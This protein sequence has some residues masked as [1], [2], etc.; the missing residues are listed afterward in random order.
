[1]CR[2]EPM[3]ALAPDDDRYNP[4]LPFSLSNRRA[5]R[6]IKYADGHP[7]EEH[8]HRKN[9]AGEDKILRR[10]ISIGFVHMMIEGKWVKTGHALVLDASHGRN[11]HPW[12]VLAQEWHTTDEKTIMTYDTEYLRPPQRVRFNDEDALG[13]LPG[14]S[15]RTPIAPLIHWNRKDEPDTSEKFFEDF[16]ENFSFDLGRMGHRKEEFSR[17]P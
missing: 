7:S 14:S 9:T 12:F 15:N 1:M 3:V 8:F 17:T 5:V 16:G 11:C 13:V 10:F 4:N 6:A 2:L